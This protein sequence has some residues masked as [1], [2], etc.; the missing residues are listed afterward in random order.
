[1]SLFTAFTQAGL[2]L[3]GE[4]LQIVTLVN[5]SLRTLSRGLGFDPATKGRGPLEQVHQ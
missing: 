5:S 1:M 2:G 3:G 4:G